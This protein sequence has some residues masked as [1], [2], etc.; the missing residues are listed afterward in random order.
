MYVVTA[1]GFEYDDETHS[2]SEG[3]AGTPVA[4]FI[5]RE[6]AY[7]DARHRTVQEF[8]LGWGGD[9]IETFGYETNGIFGRKPKCVKMHEDDFFRLDHY[10]LKDALDLESRSIEDLEDVADCLTFTPYDVIETP[11]RPK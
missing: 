9:N 3:G 7:N 5:D 1:T 4:I 11:F 6:E 10:D 8:L 2:V